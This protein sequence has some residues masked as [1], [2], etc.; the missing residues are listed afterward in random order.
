MRVR[1]EQPDNAVEIVVRRKEHVA[2]EAHPRRRVTIG[3]TR[4]ARRAGNQQASSATTARNR[5]TAAKV[6]GSAEL[7]P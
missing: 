7:T 2:E 6:V 1:R 4:A 3:S 5:A